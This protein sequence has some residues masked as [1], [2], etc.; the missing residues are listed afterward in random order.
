[1]S[2][3]N[4]IQVNAQIIKQLQ[5]EATE[6]K[7]QCE[8]EDRHINLYQQERERINYIWMNQ[9]KKIDLAKAELI[10]KTREREDLEEQQM[11]EKKLYMQKIK[12]IMLKHLDENVEIIKKSDIN[13]KQLEDE[14]RVKEKDYKY[15]K[16]STSVMLKEQEVLQ[17]E[18]LHA[19]QKDN[20]KRI[21]E[22]KYEYEIKEQQIRN[23]FRERMKEMNFN[24][25]E[26]RKKI[27]QEIN[28]KKLK[29]IKVVTDEHAQAFYNMKIYYSDLNKKNLSRL[30][31]LANNFTEQLKIQ[32]QLKARKNK[33]LNEK[34]KIEEP[35]KKIDKE[36]NENLEKEQ[37]CKKIY[38]EL[39]ALRAEYKKKMQEMLD[40]EYK[41]EV[42]L[43][44]IQYLKKEKDMYT[45]KYK[46]ELHKVQQKAGLKV[47]YF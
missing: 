12:F 19:L 28:E 22:L 16:R 29:E 41:L 6:L 20:I 43:Q 37:K 42:Y 24:M 38:L 23:Y 40:N 26:R 27:I 8:N 31:G 36:I 39:K 30:K 45:T 44:K 9:K 2:Q 1:M 46:E 21:H 17:N 25:E 47:S 11:I 35:L 7:K 3:P 5:Q 18:F 34:K 15:D 32:G 4:V 10:N 13:L 14:H 33:K